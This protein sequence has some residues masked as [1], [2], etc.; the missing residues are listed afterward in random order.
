M[1][2][3]GTVVFVVDVEVVVV[4]L[5]LVELLDDEDVV[6]LGCVVLVELV[7]VRAVKIS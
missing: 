6:V 7:A 2:S 5:V 1:D 3:A 4:E